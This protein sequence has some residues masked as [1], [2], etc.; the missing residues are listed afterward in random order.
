V[1][2]KTPISNIE[3]KDEACFVSTLNPS[4]IADYPHALRPG[5]D[6]KSLRRI[7]AKSATNGGIAW[8]YENR[9]EGNAAI[10]IGGNSNA[11]AHYAFAAGNQVNVTK[12]YSVGFGDHVNVSGN[13]SFAAGTSH[14]ASGNNVFIAGYGNKTANDNTF[15]EGRYNLDVSDKAHIVGNGTV[16]DA[17][18][19][20]YTL[21]WEGN[22]YYA[23]DVYVQGDGTTAGF[24]GAKKVATE[25]YV[26]SPKNYIVLTD[27]VT[28]QLYHIT[29][30]N[31]N[32][33]ST[34][35]EGGE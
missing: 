33:V 27:T 32:L 21:D 18:S 3:I 2:A 20:A 11:L 31:G 5:S 26:N 13:T 30:E 14:E 10:A 1:A 7:D 12:S 16:G 17:R 25:E 24:D 28:G 29:V 9:A 8:G 22:A 34:L 15:V 35:V 23:G 19:N 4:L 6:A